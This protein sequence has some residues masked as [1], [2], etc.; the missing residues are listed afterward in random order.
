MIELVERYV[1]QVGRY[2]PPKERAEIEAELRSQ[3]EDQL[4][5]RYGAAP[6]PTE[7]G[8]VLAELGEPRQL[9]SSYNRE[10]YLVGPELYPI[11][12]TILRHGWAVIPAI[13][14]FVNVFGAAV[15]DQQKAWTEV[16]L[17]TLGAVVQAS[18]YFSVIVVLFF[19]ALERSG[20]GLAELTEPF[21]PLKLPKIDDPRTVDRFEAT[22]GIVFGTVLVL[23]LL[24][25]LQIGG[26]TL[27]FNLSDPGEV[28]P[29][30]TG[31]LVILIGAISAMLLV[32]FIVLRRN[33]WN[34]AL[35]LTTTGLEIFGAV[36]LY[37]AVYEPLAQHF[38]ATVP[39]LA[40]GNGLAG[41]PE[42]LVVL[43]AGFTLLNNGTK[44]LALWNYRRNPIPSTAARAGR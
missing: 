28:I 34:I 22:F 29:V 13:V 43:S 9:A 12:M 44:L 38:S 4:E 17:E 40:D 16:I 21:D 7:I 5:D 30:P 11:M 36:C 3:I 39:A 27:R 23:A 6:T 41:L 8:S 35:Y 19:A 37:F 14:I 24:Y 32:Q 42:F 26:L 20:N 31:W 10:Q 2:L 1:H 18:V 15:S 33:R 25:F